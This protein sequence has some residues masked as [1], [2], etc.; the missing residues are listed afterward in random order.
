MAARKGPRLYIVQQPSQSIK[1]KSKKHNH[2][3]NNKNKT[4]TQTTQTTPFFCGRRPLP[5]GGSHLR[6]PSGPAGIRTTTGSLSALQTT[7]TTPQ[8][9][10]TSKME[11][12][13][14]SSPV[15]TSLSYGSICVTAIQLAYARSPSPFCSIISPSIGTSIE[16]FRLIC[17]RLHCHVSGEV[18]LVWPVLPPLGKKAGR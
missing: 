14:R 11:S 3:Q 7:Q 15:D 10:Q 6:L 8:T 18:N 2:T 9:K 1:K 13:R 5:F 12:D 17:G 4:K 16:V